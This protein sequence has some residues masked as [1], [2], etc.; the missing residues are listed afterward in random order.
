M[1]ENRHTTPEE[2]MATIEYYRLHTGAV[3]VLTGVDEDNS[4]DVTA[5]DRQSCR[6]G[7]RLSLKDTARAVLIKMW[8]AGS[9]CFFVFWGL[10]AYIAA[11][12]E[13][14]LVFGIALGLVTDLLTNGIL[15]SCAKTSGANDRWMMF[16]KNRRISFLFNI[17]YALALLYC[18]SVF[19]TLL[20]RSL[21][22]ITGNAKRVTVGVGPVLFGT[23]YT[24]FDL[25]F[26]Q[27]KRLMQ[28]IVSDAKKKE[29]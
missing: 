25:L 29:E 13:L 7:P 12:P 21:S 28:R 2:N 26:I 27:M 15:R 6:S 11:T 20:N 19:Y 5:K 24:A 8:F 14:M 4:P 9:V 3:E 1:S 17:L 10:S 22:A 23:V 18:V 16:P